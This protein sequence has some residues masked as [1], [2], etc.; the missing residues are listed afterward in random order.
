MSQ[1]VKYDYYLGMNL[2][3]ELNLILPMLLTLFNLFI[4]IAQAP[5][6]LPSEHQAALN[7]DRGG[8]V[9]DMCIY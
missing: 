5:F 7:V 6:L 3:H 8:N 2:S 1:V 4:L 9:I